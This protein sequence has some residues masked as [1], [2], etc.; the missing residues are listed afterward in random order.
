MEGFICNLL[1]V[2]LDHKDCQRARRKVLKVG[3]IV[4]NLYMWKPGYPAKTDSL[5]LM[6]RCS[7]SWILRESWLIVQTVWKIMSFLSRWKL[8]RMRK[9]GKTCCKDAVVRWKSKFESMGRIEYSNS[10]A[11]EGLG[12]ICMNVEGVGWGMI[13][14]MSGKDRRGELISMYKG[15]QRCKYGRKVQV[16]MGIY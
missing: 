9:G 14:K 3:V 4:R 5:C 1:V 15:K 12:T 10:S 7:W 16:K 13:E 6:D 2:R 8:Q 11:G